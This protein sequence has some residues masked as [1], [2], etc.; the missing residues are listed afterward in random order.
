MVA[1]ARG[2]LQREIAREEALAV[3]FDGFGDVQRRGF[4]RTLVALAVFFR[5][6]PRERRILHCSR[7][8]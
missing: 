7:E 6:A 5:E 3:E 8:V 2:D 4:E 1:A